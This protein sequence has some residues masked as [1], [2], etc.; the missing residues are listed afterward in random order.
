[1][2]QKLN[3][4]HFLGSLGAL[5]AGTVLAGCATVGPGGAAVAPAPKEIVLKPHAVG[6][7]HPQK[8][9]RLEGV[10]E[11]NM[12]EMFLGN[13]KGDKNPVFRFPAGKTMGLHIH[14]E[15]VIL[16]ELII[17]RGGVEFVESEGKKVPDGYK[18]NLFALIEGDIFIYFGEERIEIGGANFEE[19]EI[20]AGVRDVWIRFKVPEN[21][22]GEW[23]FGCFVEGHYEGGMKAKLIVE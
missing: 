11:I 21:L 14:N 13:P 4:R 19:L 2:L 12:G 20:P 7:E 16:H 10:V 5:A 9:K 8:P 22:K 3:R 23:E 15:G 17:G 1:M 18:E 6:F